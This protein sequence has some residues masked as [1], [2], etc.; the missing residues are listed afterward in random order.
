[1][2]FTYLNPVV[3]SAAI[4]TKLGSAE[5]CRAYDSRIIY[6]YS[7]DISAVADGKKINHLGAGD[8]LYIPAGIPYKLKGKYL[9]CAIVTFDVTSDS[10]EPFERIEP[11]AVAEFDESRCHFATLSPFDKVLKLSEM[12]SEADELTKL[13]N[14]FISAEGIYRFSASAILKS[15][16]LKI[17]EAVDENAL[18][19][20]MVESLDSYIRENYREDISN[21]ELGA[22][23]GYHPFYISKILKDKKGITLKQYIIKYKLSAA[24]AMLENSS[25]S[26]NE[27]A[28]ETGFTDAS[29]F[30][31]TFKSA[32]GETP[33]KYR[34]RFRDGFV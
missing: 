22:I 12:E 2:D 30:T 26:I 18:P 1:M 3:R 14:L 11:A 13:A 31:K 27:I 32:F 9:E 8:L 19:T 7:G 5:E 4:I 16:L 33:K 25:K 34:D 21:T 10:P 29:Y 24:R 23:F 6:I 28:E 15:L 20:R 17:A